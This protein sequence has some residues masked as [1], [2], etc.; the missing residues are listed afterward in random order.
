[1]TDKIKGNLTLPKMNGKEISPGIF[2]IG[3]PKPRPDLGPNSLVCLANANGALVLVEL[4]TRL[5]SN[6]D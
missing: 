4:T 1:M 6:H 3:E 2:L 5:E